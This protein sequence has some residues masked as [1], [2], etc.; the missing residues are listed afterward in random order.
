[1]NNL[2]WTAGVKDTL[3]IV[4]NSAGQTVPSA[5]WEQQSNNTWYQYTTAGSWNL[6][7]SLYI[8]P[9]LTSTPSQAIIT[10]SVLTICSGNA[11][12]FDAA[13]STYQD[14]LLWYFPGGT[15][16]VI[17]SAP[18]ASVTY[19]TPGTYDAILYTIGGGCALF[20]SAFVTITVNPTPTINVS[21]IN[22][23]CN[24][25]NTS[26]TASGASTYS[27]SP[28]SGL[29]ATTGTSVTA[30]PTSTTTYDIT[31]TLGSCSNSTSIIIT[32][33]NVSVALVEFVDSIVGCPTSVTFDGSNSSY[34]DN[35]NW[36]FPGGT[37]ST[38][39]SSSPIVDFG[40]DGPVT[41]ELITENLCG[42]DTTEF[43]LDIVTNC[44]AGLEELSANYLITYEPN[45]AVVQISNE[46][47]IQNGTMIQ[48]YNEMGQIL[49]STTLNSSLEK[50]EISLSSFAT[51]M[52][53]VKIASN[54]EEITAKVIKN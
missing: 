7:A 45:Q 26:L 42:N 24:G 9:F 54:S 16:T 23:I 27:W 30:N 13:G 32:V 20:D 41:V 28:G 8:H 4:S 1:M 35:F 18:T 49:F 21:G 39:N 29:S 25:D 15:P 11:V 47:G 14:T 6:S 48:L 40:T 38:S 43:L 33:D 37:P 44:S 51:G 2:Q 46:Q 12:D 10:P 52:Y 53:F 19:G 31:G 5:I 3:S 36:T 17:P 22:T 50:A 34:A